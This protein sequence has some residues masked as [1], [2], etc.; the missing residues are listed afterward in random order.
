MVVPHRLHIRVG[1]VFPD[2]KIAFLVQAQ[3]N[4]DARKASDRFVEVQP[5]GGILELL[6][7]ARDNGV[8]F[9]LG[10][11]QEARLHK[12]GVPVKVAACDLDQF[13]PGAVLHDAG[14]DDVL[15]D[16]VAENGGI[17]VWFETLRDPTPDRTI[18]LMAR[19]G[20]I[21]LMAG[22]AARPEFPVG[23]FYVKDLR[24]FGFAM[25]NAS[26]DEQRVCAMAINGLAEQGEWQPP[27]GRT[28]PLAE[29]AVAHQ[30][31]QDNTL[32]KQGTLTGKIVL[33]P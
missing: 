22:R 23:P 8:S 29:A 15:R 14:M 27:I 24:M 16:F 18:E 11:N 19:R 5:V 25:F 12:L 10:I 33:T 13:G 20:R 3:E 1:G 21:V 28:L 32:E 6:A 9:R 17:D 7:F 4:L 26:A 2:G 31:Q 30:L